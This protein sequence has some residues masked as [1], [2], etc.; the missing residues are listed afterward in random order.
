MLS[1]ADGASSQ[2]CSD[3]E[4][5]LSMLVA[6]VDISARIALSIGG[7]AN[8]TFESALLAGWKILGSCS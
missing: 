3:P 8:S 1:T 7:L 5:A 4:L 6:P 2:G